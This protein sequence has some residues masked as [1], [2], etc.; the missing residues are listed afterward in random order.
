M[1][2]KKNA[3]LIPVWSSCSC[4]FS[5]P[6]RTADNAERAS[7]A[8]WERAEMFQPGLHTETLRS[9][10]FLNFSIGY[11]YFTSAFTQFPVRLVYVMHCV[12]NC[13]YNTGN[14]LS[15]KMH[16]DIYL[17]ISF[18]IKTAENK[19]N[20]ELSFPYPCLVS[21]GC[22]SGTRCCILRGQKVWMLGGQGCFVSGKEL[23]L[24]PC[25][26]SQWGGHSCPVCDDWY[27]FGEQHVGYQEAWVRN[28]E[29]RDFFSSWE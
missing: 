12:Y 17:Y 5:T 29:Q 8:S 15:F 26:I 2:C 10:S 11:S 1:N 24:K 13:I 9:S 14:T 3:E 18:S 7:F 23:Q 21:S 16:K 19:N 20:T 22:W 28:H 6:C 27:V 25:V 4:I